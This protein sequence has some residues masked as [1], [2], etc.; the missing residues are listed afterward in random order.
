[1]TTP[2]PTLQDLVDRLRVY[3]GQFMVL[4]GTGE[5]RH[6]VRT[7]VNGAC[8]CPLAILAHDVLGRP[9]FNSAFSTFARAAGATIR[10]VLDFVRAADSR[11]APGRQLLVDA[12]L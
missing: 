9:T 11:S 6:K 5:I 1:M 12:L 8:A 4:P 10:T 3:K 7:C 2:D